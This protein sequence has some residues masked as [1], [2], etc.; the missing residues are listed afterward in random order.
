MKIKLEIKVFS[1]ERPNG[2]IFNKMYDASVVPN[3]GEKVKDN[4]FVEHKSV[5]D[6]IY[7]F[8]Q[9]EVKVCLISKEMPDHALNGH[10]QEV[11]TLHNWVQKIKKEED[12]K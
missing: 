11:A 7:D 3:I 1:K 12:T 10:I 5:I 4:I 8:D 9:N 2:F 6:V